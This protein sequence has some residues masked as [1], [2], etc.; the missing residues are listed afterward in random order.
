M[1]PFGIVYGLYDPDTHALRYVGQTVKTLADR[2]S[3]HLS[4]SGLKKHLRVASWLKSLAAKGRKPEAKI[5]GEAFSRPQLDTLEISLIKNALSS[6]AILTNLAP[7]GGVNSGF[8]KSPE[9]VAKIVAARTGTTI[10]ADVRKKISE[11]QLG[12]HFSEE[13]RAKIAEASRGQ[14]PT[15]ETRARMSKAWHMRGKF[16]AYIWKRFREGATGSAI[17]REIGRR[18]STVQRAILRLSTRR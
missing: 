18:Q 8:K 3:N 7:G 6:G 1:K 4:P 13:H 16:D 11:A 9:A 5:L 10:P 2:L 15:A 12:R 14:Q 17:A